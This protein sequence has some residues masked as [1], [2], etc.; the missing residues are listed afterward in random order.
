MILIW[1]QQRLSLSRTRSSNPPK[2]AWSH[3]N[4]TT[5]REEKGPQ[6]NQATPSIQMLGISEVTRH[7]AGTQQIRGLCV[8]RIL[9]HVEGV[10]PTQSPKPA[11]GVPRPLVRASCLWG[12]S[13]SP[14]EG[15]PRGG[16]KANRHSLYKVNSI[17]YWFL[18]TSEA[19]M[20]PS[21][22]LVFVCVVSPHT[23]SWP[24][25]MG[26]DSHS[27]QNPPSGHVPPWS[28]HHSCGQPDPT[29]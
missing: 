14:R 23:W 12:V 1:H 7:T 24:M 20:Y 27:P 11:P 26:W 18:N 6:V 22:F 10:R 3:V 21:L 15:E 8:H 4:V 5:W 9:T 28:G 16:K 25:Q 13:R 19:L 17:K 29:V 2:G